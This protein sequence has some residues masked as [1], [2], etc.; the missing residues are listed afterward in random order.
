MSEEVT[1][2]VRA[3]L[4]AFS[5]NHTISSLSIPL[6][7]TAL[8]HVL[9]YS[10]FYSH[11]DSHSNFHFDSHYYTVV[12][13][14]EALSR[15]DLVM[16]S[17]RKWD[18]RLRRNGSVRVGGIVDKGIC[19]GSS[20]GGTDRGVEGV[21]ILVVQILALW[22]N[23]SRRR[24]RG[25]HGFDWKRHHITSYHI[26]WHR[27]IFHCMWH[28]ATPHVINKSHPTVH[29]ITSHWRT[30]PEEFL[31]IAFKYVIVSPVRNPPRFRLKSY[32]DYGNSG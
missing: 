12:A 23:V 26:S 13:F 19:K 21:E 7:S 24:R 10:H 17:S 29:N 32:R 5:T 18:T 25:R 4:M 8:H 2:A 31:L 20:M 9:F 22:R 6:H 1:G 30:V 28:H 14:L 3:S 15:P 27:I 11:F 16:T